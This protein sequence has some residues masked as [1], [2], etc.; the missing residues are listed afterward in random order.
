LAEFCGRTLD[1]PTVSA[2]AFEYRIRSW[3]GFVPLGRLGV[4]GG[5]ETPN[6]GFIES[7]LFERD[8]QPT[9]ENIE[10]LVPA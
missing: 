1:R 2:I 10:R 3:F 4:F 5:T 7:F 8:L 6:L 9:S